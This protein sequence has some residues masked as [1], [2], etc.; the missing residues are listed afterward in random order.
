M[1]LWINIPSIDIGHYITIIQRRSLLKKIPV[2]WDL[3]MFT[4]FSF[5]PL[6][7]TVS[8]VEAVKTIELPSQLSLPTRRCQ[9]YG[10]F[11]VLGARECTFY[12]STL[13]AQPLSRE[14]TNFYSNQHTIQANPHF[15]TC[16]FMLG[17]IYI[18]NL[19]QGR[20]RPWDTIRERPWC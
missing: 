16:L 11:L 2:C 14:C 9:L 15:P 13:I 10:K 18:F 1:I 17:F 7:S 5:K 6:F 4:F 8:T 12:T 19:A 3:L 20:L